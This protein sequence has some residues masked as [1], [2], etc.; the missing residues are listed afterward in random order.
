MK[1]T[2]IR[3]NERQ[4]V[5]WFDK[6]R[7][8]RFAEDRRHDGSNLISV[9]TGSQWAHEALFLTRK[10]RWIINEW[11]DWQGSAETYSF[12]DERDAFRW[13]VANRYDEVML[14]TA[15]AARFLT[16]QEA[17]EA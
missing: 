9:A 1:R 17:M 4:P 5:G 14:P 7:A 10:H 13:L 11:S 12:M 2:I 6:D 16:Y 8:T 15:I 3:D